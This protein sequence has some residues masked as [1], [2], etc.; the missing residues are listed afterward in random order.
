MNVK[1]FI[2]GLLQTNCYLVFDDD[3]HGFVIDPGFES[4]ALISFIKV[5]K[6][7]IDYILITHAHFD[8]ISFV[9][10]LK[11][12]TG[13]KICLAENDAP[14][15]EG[16]YRFG[17]KRFGYKEKVFAP[18]IILKDGQMIKIGEI[19]IKVI[20]TPGHS[21]GGVCYYSENENILF[22]GD[23]LFKAAIGR[24]DLPGSSEDSIWDSLMKKVLVLPEQTRVLPGHGPETT[25]KEEQR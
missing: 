12:M 8:H 2:V 20:A 21:P 3:Q 25:I 15:I 10:D 4:E 13:A 17:A 19:K 24:T 1:K 22:T 18:D 14:L 7:K 23:T 5:N 9:A 11:I 16:S 6:I